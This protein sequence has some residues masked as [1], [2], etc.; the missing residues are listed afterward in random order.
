MQQARRQRAC[1]ARMCGLAVLE[2]AHVRV[3]EVACAGP[4]KI[5]FE[6]VGSKSRPF[7]ARLARASASVV[8]SAWSSASFLPLS[9][10]DRRTRRFPQCA[11]CWH[12]RRHR[13]GD[14]GVGIVVGVRQGVSQGV[15]MGV[16]GG[17]TFGVVVVG[18][19]SRADPLPRPRPSPCTTSWRPT[20]SSSLGP[21][22]PARHAVP[23]VGNFGLRPHVPVGKHRASRMVAERRQ[24]SR[25]SG[26]AWAS[27]R[28]GRHPTMRLG[29]RP[30]SVRMTTGSR[31]RCVG[32]PRTQQKQ[33]PFG[34]TNAGL[35]YIRGC[36]RRLLVE[37]GVETHRRAAQSAHVATTPTKS[38]LSRS[39][40]ASSCGWTCSAGRA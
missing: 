15:A 3:I 30:G 32:S 22:A 19:R 17:I 28:G 10:S 23:I 40:I 11:R 25:D 31:G 33:H 21:P 37:L 9:S 16:G 39:S 1:G 6:L 12:R 20:R 14:V 8:L 18:V 2:G 4:F 26:A 35:L 24:A 5:E 34:Q 13:C 29:A 7:L 38:A 36:A 27:L